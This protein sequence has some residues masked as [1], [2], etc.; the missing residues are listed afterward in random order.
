MSWIKLTLYLMV[1]S[2]VAIHLVCGDAEQTCDAESP[3]DTV[4][5]EE[6]GE[7]CGCS[8]LNRQKS[9]DALD[10]GKEK[11]NSDNVHRTD[12]ASYPR[13]NQMVLLEGG[14]FTMGTDDPKIPLDGESPAREV[15]LVPFYFDVYETSNAEF[16][17]FAN[18]TGYLTEAERFGD[19][20]VLEVRISEEIKKDITQ[21]VA[22]APWWLPVK[23]RLAY[24][25]LEFS[26]NAENCKF[27]EILDSYLHRI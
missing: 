17:R 24:T 5:T 23:V 2:V 12:E 13:T 26:Q 27:Q 4:D 20:F 16:E 25:Q 15:T 22:A 7:G 18:S 19:S 14:T 8:T 6:Q 11:Y 9:E 3:C 21:A 1:L 10:S